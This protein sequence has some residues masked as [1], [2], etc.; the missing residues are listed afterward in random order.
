MELRLDGLLQR[1]LKRDR[2]NIKG[3]RYK[4]R[5]NIFKWGLPNYS[6]Q[7]SK[8]IRVSKLEYN[9]WTVWKITITNAKGKR[10]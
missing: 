3:I 5:G 1:Y 10:W 8:N 2:R 9:R 7:Y 4:R 6:K